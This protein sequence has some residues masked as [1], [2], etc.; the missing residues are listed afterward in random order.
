MKEQREK[1]KSKQSKAGGG[2]DNRR[3]G[4]REPK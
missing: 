1:T 4:S 3:G 2:A